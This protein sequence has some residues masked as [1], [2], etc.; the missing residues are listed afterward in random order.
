[1]NTFISL[2]P[3]MSNAFG[4]GN[5]LLKRESSTMT[6]DLEHFSPSML[7]KKTVGKN[8][9]RDDEEVSRAKVG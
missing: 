5:N 3:T 1:M 7:F 8:G 4:F 2:Q 9:P 6:E